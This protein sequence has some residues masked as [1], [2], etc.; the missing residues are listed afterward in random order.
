MIEITGSDLTIQ[1]I[2]N[3]ARRKIKIKIDDDAQERIA[4]SYEI[5]LSQAKKEDPIYGINTGFGVFSN[6]RISLIESKEL[7]R[8]LIFSHAV[9]TGEPLPEEIVRAA[10]VVRVNTLSKGLSGVNPKLVKTLIDMLNLN[11]IP[12][13]PSKGSMGSSGDLCLLAQLG[14]VM[15]RDDNNIGNESGKVIFD[16][17]LVSGKAAMEKA[18]IERI[19]F[20]YKDGLALINGATFSAAIAA[21]C[22]YDAGN[23]LKIASAALSLSLEALCG[24]SDAFNKDIHRARNIE[25][26]TSIASKVR[27]LISGSTFIDGLEQIQDAYSLRCAPQVHGAVKETEK[28]VRTIVTK[29]INA[30]TDNPLLC[31]GNEFKSGGNFHGEPVGM[32]ADFLSIALSELGA[33]SERRI[34]KLIDSNL[35]N[36]LPAML[37]G[38]SAKEGLNSGIMILQYTAAA[39]ALENQTCA[40]PDS[41]KSLPTSANQEDHNANAYNAAINLSKIVTNVTK[42]LS[43]ELYSAC[44]GIELRKIQFQKRKLGTGTQMLFNTINTEFPFYSSDIQW[45]GE[46]ERLYQLMFIDSILK[47]ELLSVCD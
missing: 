44:R 45:G 3:I 2:A 38:P 8:N 4:S 37:V 7:N 20:T 35:N 23:L 39:L 6:K 12:L 24:R 43:I 19:E 17:K 16:A 15:M 30:A 41:I 28:F 34:F 46:L 13:V 42:I 32:V 29:E 18:G 1:D 21:L 11:V 26:Q 40:C 36:G 31:N 47:R 5:M 14:L 9:A 27:D 25:G 10:M 22:V 33:I